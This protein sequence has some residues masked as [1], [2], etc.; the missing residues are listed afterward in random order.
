MPIIN[1][2]IAGYE[3]GPEGGTRPKEGYRA[4]GRALSVV[5]IYQSVYKYSSILIICMAI[6]VEYQPCNQTT[7]GAILAFSSFETFS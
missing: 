4:T 2:L 6:L 3:A 7:Q 5:V 1:L